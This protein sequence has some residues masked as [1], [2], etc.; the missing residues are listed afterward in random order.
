MVVRSLGD[1]NDILCASLAVG[2]MQ[3]EDIDGRGSHGLY[4]GL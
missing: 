3:D 1:V 4:S 2:V